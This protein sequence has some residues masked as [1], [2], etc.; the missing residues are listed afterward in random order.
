CDGAGDGRYHLSATRVKRTCDKFGR[1]SLFAKV[2]GQA[3]QLVARTFF[4]ASGRY[5][6]P[7]QR[8]SVLD[9]A[10]I[11]HRHLVEMVPPLC[12]SAPEGEPRTPPPGSW[13]W[14]GGSTPTPPA[15]PTQGWERKPYLSARL[16]PCN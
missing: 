9:N 6:K 3:V 5:F 11:N 10:E 8:S 7:V 2:R 13:T 15:P 12:R 4:P 1:G 14:G 16:E